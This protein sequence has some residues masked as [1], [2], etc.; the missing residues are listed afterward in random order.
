MEVHGAFRAPVLGAIWEP[1]H[2]PS[3]FG[4]TRDHDSPT[5]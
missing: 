2:S 4:T 5:L 3:L 1:T